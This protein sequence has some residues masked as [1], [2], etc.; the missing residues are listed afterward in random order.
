VV[1]GATTAIGATGRRDRALF[2][3]LAAFDGGFTVDAGAAVC[4]AG[5]DEAFDAIAVLIDDRLRRMTD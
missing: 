3:R 4:G 5:E 2:R 1:A